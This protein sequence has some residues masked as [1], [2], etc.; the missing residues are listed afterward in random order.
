MSRDFNYKDFVN[1]LRFQIG[2][3]CPDYFD[4]A[5]EKYV[6]KHVYDSAMVAAKSL[7]Q[8]PSV[9]VEACEIITRTIAEWTFY[10]IVDLIYGDVPIEFHDSILSSIN[11]SIYEHL[12]EQNTVE[13]ITEESLRSNDYAKITADIVKSVYRSVLSK[14]YSDK[15]IDKG[16]Y[17]FALAQSYKELEKSS[18][19]DDMPKETKKDLF[20]SLNGRCV[21]LN[22]IKKWIKL[23]KFRFIFYFLSVIPF[24]YL[25]FILSDVTKINSAYMKI[26]WGFYLGWLLVALVDT[27]IKITNYDSS[28]VSWIINSLHSKDSESQNDEVQLNGPNEMYQRLGV[29]VLSIRLGS[30]LIDFADPDAENCLLPMISNLRTELTDTLGY[31]MPNI[32]CMDDMS[33][34]PNEFGIYVRGVRR[35]T[36]FAEAGLSNAKIVELIKTHLRRCCIKY[37]NEI[38]SR[39]DILKIMTLVESEN[40]TLVNDLIPTMISAVDLR[41]IFVALVQEE[42]PIKDVILI[43]E[44][45]CE[46]ARL[47]TSPNVLVER[48]RVE[49]APQICDKYTIKTD[50]KPVLYTAE[51]SHEV[52]NKLFNSV[53]VTDFCNFIKLEASE[54]ENLVTSVLEK[55]NELDEHREDLVLL[56]SPK[57]RKPLFDILSKHIDNIRVMS[58]AEL[59]Q[60]IE[61]VQLCEI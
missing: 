15:K 34:K 53:C 58:F 27:V 56:V 60:D 24:L 20:T 16:I 10:K 4:E 36:F 43:F 31:I 35:D 44:R 38:I 14:L 52:E 23:H 49:M 51:L 18:I 3:G 30:D 46:V 8:N 40:P 54:L 17:T 42:I 57:I 1:M 26:V 55:L 41:R 2:G 39:T 19:E 37:A 48:L 22:S 59:S 21:Y 6:R 25:T 7:Y 11:S 9:K 47:N 12:V 33:Y 32:R 45:L 50:N 29:D 28:G 13:E 61:V 5:M